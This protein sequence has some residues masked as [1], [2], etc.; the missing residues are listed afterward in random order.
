MNNKLFNI[1]QV[2]NLVKMVG[3]PPSELKGVSARCDELID[4]ITTILAKSSG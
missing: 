2:P 3:P 1:S 4:Q